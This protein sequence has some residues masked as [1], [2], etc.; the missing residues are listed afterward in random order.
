VARGKFI[1]KLASI[2]SNTHFLTG[3]QMKHQRTMRKFPA[4]M[5]KLIRKKKIIKARQKLPQRKRKS[6]KIFALF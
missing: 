3:H 1:V 4:V 6:L 2:F 5:K